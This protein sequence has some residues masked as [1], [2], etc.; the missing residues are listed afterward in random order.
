MSRPRYLATTLSQLRNFATASSHCHHGFNCLVTALLPRRGPVTWLRCFAT[1]PRLRN[2]T[3][4]T[5]QRCD[6]SQPSYNLAAGS[7]ASSQAGHGFA[8]L[9]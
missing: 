2:A 3:I 6:A 5:L 4:A 1:L 9:P 8:M 7:I